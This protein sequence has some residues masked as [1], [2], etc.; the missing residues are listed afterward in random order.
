MV[1]RSMRDVGSVVKDSVEV[2]FGVV[3]GA[4]HSAAGGVGRR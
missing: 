4:V 2:V 3:E 1:A